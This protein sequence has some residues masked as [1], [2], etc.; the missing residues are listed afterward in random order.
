MKICG[1]ELKGNDAVICLLSHENG[2][3]HLPDCRVAKL[4]IGNANDTQE[5]KK[6]QFSFAKLIEDY[7][8]EKVVIRQRQTKGKFAGGAVGFKLEAAIQLIDDLK[9]EVVAPTAIKESL[10]R[11][12]LGIQFKDTGLKQYQEQAFTTAYACAMMRG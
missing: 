6:F 11:N 10:K 7:K 8:I 3:V 12:P 4:S 2:V 9:V 5:M 1:V